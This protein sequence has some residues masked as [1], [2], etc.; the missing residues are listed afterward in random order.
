M[1]GVQKCCTLCNVGLNRAI[2]LKLFYGTGW[3]INKSYLALYPAIITISNL[4]CE[5]SFRQNFEK[6]GY[7]II[8]VTSDPS[9]DKMAL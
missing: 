3:G 1:R 4:V 5:V 9:F 7:D 6:I 2:Y 8:T